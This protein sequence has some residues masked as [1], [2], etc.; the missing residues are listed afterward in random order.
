[1]V[2]PPKSQ[3]FFHPAIH[4]LATKSEQ[5][6]QNAQIGKNINSFFIQEGDSH[7]L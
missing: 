2:T 3:L 6:K 4:P 5:M 7:K 1:V